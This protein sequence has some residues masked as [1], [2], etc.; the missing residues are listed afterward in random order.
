M[1]EKLGK[2]NKGITLI[3]LV[4]TI[5]VLLILAGVTIATLTG[6]NGILSKVETAKME[7]DE[8]KIVEEIK[9]GYNAVK[10][11]SNLNGWNKDTEAAELETELTNMNQ[12]DEI[13]AYKENLKDGNEVI[14]VEYVNRD[15]IYCIDDNSEIHECEIEYFLGDIQQE[16]LDNGEYAIFTLS[17][18]GANFILCDSDPNYDSLPSTNKGE[19]IEKKYD[20]EC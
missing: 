1:I 3:A 8:G 20:M 2:T 14:I 10:I 18:A 16:T 15:K 4:I 19:K 17:S 13:I 7:T 9:L 5:I 6:D 12:T 11:G